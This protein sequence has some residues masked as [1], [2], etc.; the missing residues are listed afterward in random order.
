MVMGKLAIHKS[1]EQIPIATIKPYTGIHIYSYCTLTKAWQKKC[2]LVF[3]HNHF[4]D[5]NSEPCK[6]CMKEGIHPT[7]YFQ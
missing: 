3:S 6:H 7:H 5:D 2:D 1:D 4:P